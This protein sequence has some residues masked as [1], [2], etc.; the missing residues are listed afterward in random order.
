MTIEKPRRAHRPPSRIRY[1]QTH[2]VLGTRVSR[3]DYDAVKAFQAKNG[4]SFATFVRVA[5]KRES[6]K[7]DTAWKTGFSAA[8]RKYAVY[9]A[10]SVCGGLIPITTQEEAQVAIEAMQRAQWGHGQCVDGARAR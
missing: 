4:W 6:S 8:K 1:D 3:R 2:P 5:L 9:Y 7:Y 10:C